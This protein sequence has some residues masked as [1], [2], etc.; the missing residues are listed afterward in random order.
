MNQP[1][2]VPRDA[3]EA[4]ERD[5]MYAGIGEIMERRGKWKIVDREEMSTCTKAEA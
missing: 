1:K 2:R 5:P 3:V 4:L